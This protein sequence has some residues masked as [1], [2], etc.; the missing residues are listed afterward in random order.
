[1]SFHFPNQQGNILC[2]HEYVYL[3]IQ[4]GGKGYMFEPGKP[5]WSAFGGGTC[6]KYVTLIA[7]HTTKTV[8]VRIR[9]S[10][11]TRFLPSW[12]LS[13]GP[14]TKVVYEY[15]GFDLLQIWSSPD[16]VV[17]TDSI[18]RGNYQWGSVE[19]RTV[20]KDYKIIYLYTI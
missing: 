2:A 1:M 9:S 7:P 18:N 3:H 10:M 8:S 15:Y 4:N 14:G 5:K 13:A 20:I 16:K 19:T 11:K 12:G 6:F 17:H